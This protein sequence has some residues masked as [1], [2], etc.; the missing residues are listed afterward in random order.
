MVSSCV[1]VCCKSDHI[2]GGIKSDHIQG[3]IKSDHIQGGIKSDHIQSGMKV[4]CQCTG[5]FRVT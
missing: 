1:N 2:Q 5:S 3:G 4:L